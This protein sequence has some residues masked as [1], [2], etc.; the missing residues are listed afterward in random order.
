VIAASA[1][2]ALA[3]C[4]NTQLPSTSAPPRQ[5]AGPRPSQPPAKDSGAP[6]KSVAPDA[7]PP[8]PVDVDAF[9][10]TLPDSFCS[11]EVGAEC[12]GVEDCATGKVCCGLLAPGLPKYFLIRCM[13]TCDSLN[14]L[15]PGYELCHVGDTCRNGSAC[16]RSSLIP[17]EFIGVCFD[18]GRTDKPTGKPRKGEI[19]CGDETCKVGTEQCC[20]RADLPLG[21]TPV[22]EAPYCQPLGDDCKCKVDPP[23]P[24]HGGGSEND[25]GH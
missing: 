3:A 7:S 15:T 25:A 23:K 2:C 6:P 20:L 5:D 12:D 13:E 10:A 21:S 4:D 1:L 19:N 9:I 16:S 22:A 17:Q 14:P 8:P 11:L 18:N 24:G